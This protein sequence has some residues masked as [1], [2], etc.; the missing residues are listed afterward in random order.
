VAVNKRH[1]QDP[2]IVVPYDERWPAAFVAERQR[3]LDAI[4]ARGAV[5]EHVGSTAVVG[6]AAK[7]VIDI[8]IGL[9]HLDEAPRWIAGLEP[10]GY[11]YVPCFEDVMPERRYFRR[12]VGSE[13]SQQIHMVARDTAF[14]SR[15]LA[16]RDFLRTHPQDL[17]A[18]ASLKLALGATCRDNREAYMDGKDAF[19]KEMEARAL[20]CY[21]N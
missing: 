16:F 6:L 7:P 10:L 9:S 5:I 19:I 11:E 4:P 1:P 18:Y 21:K 3:I 12:F 2:V 17:A 14:W 15:H 13:R 8:M 20:V